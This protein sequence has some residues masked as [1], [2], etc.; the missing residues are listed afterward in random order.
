MT[1]G[2]DLEEAMKFWKEGKNLTWKGRIGV[3]WVFI[4]D[5]P[6]SALQH[7]VLPNNENRP[8][9]F[10]RDTQEVLYEQ[11]CQVLEIFAN[12]SS[13]ESILSEF[14]TYDRCDLVLVGEEY[15]IFLFLTSSRT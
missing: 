15:S 12:A 2:V 3:E 4:K 7:I 1:S 10:T 8:V 6:N 9:T 14:E 11:G 5:V 13:S